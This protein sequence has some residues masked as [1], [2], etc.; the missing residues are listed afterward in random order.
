MDKPIVVALAEGM[1]GPQ[2]DKVA[3]VS[4]RVR[5]AYVSNSGEPRDDVSNAEVIYRG[6]GL[7]PP[8]LRRLLPSMPKL[9]WI[10]VMGAGVDGD[11]APQVVN[12]DVVV[13]RTRGLHNLPVSEWVMLQVLAVTKRLP[14]L[15][16]AQHE[17]KWDP[18]EVPVTIEGR[19][20]GIVGYGEIGQTLAVRA[21]AFGLRL[22]GTRRHPAPAPELDALY[23]SNE[24]DRLLEQ[25]DYVVILTPLTPETRGLIGEPQLRR[26]KAAAWLVNVARGEVVDEGALVRALRERW[27][28]GAALDVFRQE[29][30]PPDNPLWKLPN[31]LITPHNGGVRHPNFSDAALNQFLD[32]L[33]RYVRGEPLKNQVDKTAGY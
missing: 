19:T 17:G 22:V 32:N 9:R 5:I 31:V 16:L 33:G 28:A 25:S 18:V 2:A 10:H 24:L 23:P 3:A 14:E 21:R 11:L 8:G 30:L 29:P 27:I 12:G 13:T 7:M 15:V 1:R 26:M 4:P 6:F 20:M